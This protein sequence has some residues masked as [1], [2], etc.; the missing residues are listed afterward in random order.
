LIPDAPRR[1]IFPTI[2]IPDDLKVCSLIDESLENGMRNL[3]EYAL[4][5]LM[6]SAS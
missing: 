2:D 6:L 3:Y 5:L 4:A 1:P